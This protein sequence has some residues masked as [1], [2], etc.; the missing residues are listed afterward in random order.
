MFK[1]LK[2]RGFT[3]RLYVINFIISH[4]I[5]ATSLVMTLF[6]SNFGIIDLSPCTVA[7]TASYA[8]L[9][10]HTGFIIVKAKQENK[11]KSAMKLVEE[12]ANQHGID[13]VVQLA[14]IILRD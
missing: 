13:S 4:I 1:Y 11:R 7:I 2:S 5:V 9:G 8:E 6:A 3:D 14:D 12:I 10:L